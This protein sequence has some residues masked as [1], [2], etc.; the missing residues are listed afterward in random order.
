METGYRW[1]KSNATLSAEE[2]WRNVAAKRGLWHPS[3]T[4]VGPPPLLVAGLFGESFKL[5]K[6]RWVWVV[7]ASCFGTALAMEYIRA[8]DPSR[9]SACEACGGRRDAVRLLSFHLGTDQP[10]ARHLLWAGQLSRHDV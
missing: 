7:S 9:Q 4:I 10:R 1:N 8:P 5:S 2:T 3:S 6:K